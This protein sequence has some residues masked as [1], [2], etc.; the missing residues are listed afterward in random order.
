MELLGEAVPFIDVPKEYKE[1]VNRHIFGFRKLEHYEQFI[2]LLVKVRAP[3]LSKEFKPTKVYEILNESLQT[4]T[5]EDLAVVYGIH[6]ETEH[7][8]PPAFEAFYQCRESGTCGDC[9]T[10]G[11]EKICGVSG[12]YFRGVCGRCE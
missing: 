7:G 10:D 3:R 2:K 4:L 8:L 5:E 11:G 12:E 9:K 1:L 6:F